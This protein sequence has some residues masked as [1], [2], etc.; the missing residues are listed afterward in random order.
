MKNHQGEKA[1][2]CSSC[3][4][5]GLSASHCR[6]THSHCGPGVHWVTT[7]LDEKEI[8]PQCY[9]SLD[10]VTFTTDKTNIAVDPTASISHLG[11]Q[12][13]QDYGHGFLTNYCP[14][15]WDEWR[16][17]FEHQTGTMLKLCTGSNTSK[18]ANSGVLKKG[19]QRLQYTVSWRQQYT[20]FRGGQPR[21]K[22]SKQCK[23]PRNAPGSRL[24]GCTATL[25]LRLLKLECGEVLDI[26]FPLPSAHSGHSLKSFAD[27]HSFKPLPEVTARVES[28][29]CNSYLSQVSLKLSLNEWVNKELIPR[30]IK[31]G[32]LEDIPSEYD[33]HYH[34]TI[35]DLRNMTKRVIN[36]IRKN[37]FDQDA[38]ET[39]LKDESKQHPG[40]R[41]FLR[42]YNTI[43][44]EAQ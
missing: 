43:D 33:R 38:L 42:K 36:K 25:N 18:E 31:Q 40:F 6:L 19:S 32:I 39:F 8:L 4:E 13:L 20:C 22:L 16:S 17:S 27:M 15:K 34:P 26:T 41:Y 3:F 37:M 1:A 7:A 11:P 9:F 44:D 5:Q 24:S 14:Q 30:H 2:P 10:C 21:Y 29:L 23:K 28:L 35:Q 12:C